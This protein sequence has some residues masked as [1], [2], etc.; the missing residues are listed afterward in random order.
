MRLPG[1]QVSKSK[2]WPAELRI[3]PDTKIMQRDLGRQARLKSAKVMGPFALEA[4][5]RPE[6]LIHG[7][8]DLAY[9]CPPTSE[10][11]GPRRSAMALRWAENLG[12]IGLPPGLMVG[13]PRAALVDDIRP[14]GRAAHARQAR[15]GMAAE[16][17]ARLR[18]G[19][20]FGTGRPTAEA[21]AHSP[22]GVTARSPG[23]PAYQPSRWL[24]PISA[25]PG[26]Q[27]AVIP[28]YS[29]H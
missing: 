8:H 1:H 23:K 5:G 4:E 20:L 27:P 10:P 12:A 3:E 22:R 6:L 21:G 13:V 14:T 16:R 11:L 7:R 29:S 26:S 24:P 18:Q 2:A 28:E 17:K 9:S 19:L 15:V 25:S